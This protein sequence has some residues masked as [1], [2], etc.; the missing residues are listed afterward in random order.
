MTIT[1]NR[2]SK[3]NHLYLVL[4]LIAATFATML[5][6]VL[7]YRNSIT[8]AED[9]LKLQAFGIAASLEASLSRTMQ[10]KDNIFKDII[11]EGMWEGIAFIALYDKNGT[12]IL[13]SNENLIGKR[14]QDEFFKTTVDTGKTVYNYVT[15]G[16]GEEVFVLNSPVHIQHSGRVLR[17]ALH[18]YHAEKII[19]QARIQILSISIVIIVLWIMG[20][21]IIKTLKRSEELKTIMEE[22]ERLAVMGEM[23]SVLAHEIRNPLGS[24]KGFAQYLM[25]RNKE[26]V[27]QNIDMGKGY[28][29]I[30]VSEAKRLETLTEDLLIYAKP[31]EARIAEFNI[32]KLAEEIIHSLHPLREEKSEVSIETLVP[33]NLTIKSDREKLRQII[34]NIVQNSIDAVKG[35]GIVSVKAERINDKIIITISDNGCGMNSDTKAKAF[36][37]FFTTKARGT[38]LGLAIVENLTKSIG[39]TIELESELQKGTIF[40]IIIPEHYS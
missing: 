8:A 5:S 29:D 1:H 22:K 32:H 40:R 27:P 2:Y 33:D 3:R 38:G 39:G 24:I 17:I 36:K 21:F 30:I 9:S 14:M 12:T 6:T 13:H 15:L 37:P 7:T 16:T 25:E 31:V 18:T 28:L 10:G 4:I 23:A 11:T 35:S 19:R 26:H 34:T 20:Y